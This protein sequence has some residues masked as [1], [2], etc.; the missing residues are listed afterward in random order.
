MISFVPGVVFEGGTLG[1][2]DRRNRD[3]V[4]AWTWVHVGAGALAAAAGVPAGLFAAGSVAYEVFEQFYERGS[5]AFGTSIPESG[6]NVLGDLAFNA[7]G[8]WIGWMI[9]RRGRA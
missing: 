3:F 5:N 9:V 7:L 4:D 1:E 8:Y 2:A 6:A